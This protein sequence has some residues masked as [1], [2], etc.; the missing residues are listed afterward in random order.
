MF[1]LLMKEKNGLLLRVVGRICKYARIEPAFDAITAGNDDAVRPSFQKLVVQKNHP[2]CVHELSGTMGHK[3]ITWGFP[4]CSLCR[5][6]IFE[7]I[8]KLSY[9]LGHQAEQQIV[10][11]TDW[12]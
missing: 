12:K 2:L 1:M 11:L 10:G 4:T 3:W 7:C 8:W 9:R 5:S 6:K